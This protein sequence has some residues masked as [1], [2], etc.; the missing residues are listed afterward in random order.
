MKKFQWPWISRKAAEREAAE[1]RA[2]AGA[3]ASW[4]YGAALEELR[5]ELAPVIER[6]ARVAVHRPETDPRNRRVR[7]V[8]EFDELAI[9]RVFEHGDD[10]RA[11]K[12]IASTIGDNAA[13]AIRSMNFLRPPDMIPETVKWR[14]HH[15]PNT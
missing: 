5:A 2:R 12:C 10:R 13:E 11:I 6:L 15:D 9:Y 8:V 3:E 1:A 14:N 7:I 4:H